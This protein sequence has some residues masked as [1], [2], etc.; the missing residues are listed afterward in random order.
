MLVRIL[1]CFLA[2]ACSVATAHAQ[3]PLRAEL[4]GTGLTRPIGVVFDPV[5]PGAVH[6]V[7]QGGLVLTFYNGGFRSTPFLDLTSVVS[8]GDDERGLLGLAFPPDAATSGRVFVN[9]TNRTGAGNTVVARFTRSSADPLVLD[10]AS[11]FDLQFPAAGGGRQGFIVQDF[12]NHN[13]GNLAFGPDGYLYIGLGDGGAGD[14][15]NNRAQTPTTLLGKML[16]I[17][18]SG[19]PA[20]GYAVPADNPD[21]NVH[22]IGNALPEIWSFGLRNPWRYS[23]DD[24]GPGATGAL[25]IADVGQGA[26]EEIDYEPAGRGGLNYGW[27]TFEGTLINPNS[28]AMPAFQPVTAPT[29]EYTHAV[30]QVITGGYVYRGAALGAFYQGRYFYSDCA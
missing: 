12:T 10:P 7:Q 28:S 2:V 13:G 19:S 26:R 17:D 30:G 5:V 14:D 9:F 23:F 1:W 3:T 15:P 25:V 20:N 11:R 29:Y 4:L 24:V 22:G 6:V 21:F 18:V 8:G 27:S 16:R